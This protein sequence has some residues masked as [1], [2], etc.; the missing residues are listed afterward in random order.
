VIKTHLF[1]WFLTV[2]PA[3]FTDVLIMETVQTQNT[4]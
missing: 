1:G 2:Q 3:N 4:I